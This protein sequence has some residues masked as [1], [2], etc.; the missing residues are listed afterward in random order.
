M[1]T[2]EM[3]AAER[4]ADLEERLSALA[5]EVARLAQPPAPAGPPIQRLERPPKG[6]QLFVLVRE[7]CR[8]CDGSG[9]VRNE[10]WDNLWNGVHGDP[11]TVDL[12][13]FRGEVG[14]GLI[15]CKPCQ[16]FGYLAGEMRL[17]EAVA[18]LDPQDVD[19]LRYDLRPV[20]EEY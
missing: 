18:R 10:K 4:I 5:V 16:G 14:P 19:Q 15:P 7:R 20:G 2:D 17:A 3:T 13:W 9:K 8:N 1:A 6:Q 11:A 12:A